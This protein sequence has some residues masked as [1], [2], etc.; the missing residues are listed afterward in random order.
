M[1]QYR[2]SFTVL[3]PFLDQEN[4]PGSSNWTFAEGKFNR[5]GKKIEGRNEKPR[6]IPHDLQGMFPRIM[7]PKRRKIRS[8]SFAHKTG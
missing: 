7:P 5:V 6:N 4:L 2:Y 8:A 3:N 1:I